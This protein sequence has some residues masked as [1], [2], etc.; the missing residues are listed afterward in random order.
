M[1]SDRPQVPLSFPL[2]LCTLPLRAYLRGLWFPS[3]PVCKSDHCPRKP[4]F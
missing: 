4:A 1:G 2:P 3:L